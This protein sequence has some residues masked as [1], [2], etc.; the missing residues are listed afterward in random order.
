MGAALHLEQL[1]NHHLLYLHTLATNYEY[2]EIDE[3]DDP[4][5]KNN[6]VICYV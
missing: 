3:I 5:V 1:I 6:F 2:D 4:Q